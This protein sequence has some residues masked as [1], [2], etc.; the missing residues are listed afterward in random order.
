MILHRTE[1]HT[2]SS[3]GMI[4]LCESV[5]SLIFTFLETFV[6]LSR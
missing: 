5:V 3:D 6:S 2:S 1:E 4:A